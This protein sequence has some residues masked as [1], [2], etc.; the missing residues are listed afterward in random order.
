MAENEGQETT[1]PPEPVPEIT[2][3]PSLHNVHKRSEDPP[4]VREVP[5]LRNSI[6]GGGGSEE[7]DRDR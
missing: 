7:R 2:D 4:A 3:V 5:S 1:P 6:V